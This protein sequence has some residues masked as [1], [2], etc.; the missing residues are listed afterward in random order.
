MINNLKRQCFKVN[1]N[2]NYSESLS[3]T[4]LFFIFKI[5]KFPFVE[6]DSNIIY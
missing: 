6:R 5:N 1:F 3:K 4:L 2:K